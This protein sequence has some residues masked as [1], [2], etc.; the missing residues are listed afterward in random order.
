MGPSPAHIKISPSL[1]DIVIGP[2]TAHFARRL[3]CADLHRTRRAAEADLLPP[4][5]ASI[6]AAGS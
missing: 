3:A 1:T 6:L 5:A 4:S 2:L